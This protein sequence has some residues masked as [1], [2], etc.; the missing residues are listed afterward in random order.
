MSTAELLKPQTEAVASYD[1]L[2]SSEVISRMVESVQP[3]LEKLDMDSYETLNELTRTL[4]ALEGQAGISEFDYYQNTQYRHLDIPSEKVAAFINGKTVLVSGGTGLIGSALL[5]ELSTFSPSRLVSISRGK[6]LPKQVLAGVEYKSVDIRDSLKL[7]EVMQQVQPDIVYHVAADKYN[8]E[9]EGRA[10]HTLST[11]VMGMKNMLNTAEA[12]GVGH[13]IYASTGK[14]SRPY[15]PDIYASSKKAGEML[16]ALKAS[17]GNMLCTAGRFTH[18]VDD[19]SLVKKVTG[20]IDEGEPVCIHNPGT[21]FY[22]QSA[23]ES[24]QLLINAGLEAEPGVLKIQAIRNLGMPVNLAKFG[25]GAIARAGAEVPIYFKGIEQGYEEKAWPGLYHPLTAVD[26]GPLT[27]S[28]EA[29]N[30]HPSPTCPEIDA[31][32][33]ELVDSP[34]L[35]QA[36][37]KL[38]D[39]LLKPVEN[40]NSSLRDA[41]QEL[42][43]AMLD[44]RLDALP[45]ELLNRTN[46]HV[47]SLEAH[48]PQL[49][50]HIDVNRALRSAI[51]RRT[52]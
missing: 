43:W 40:F 51:A 34:S 19:S 18:V 1:Y 33:L 30:A 41:N 25:I 22:V 2:T 27:S 36:Y 24:A 47:T 6:M 44:A 9:A 35:C 42:S 5:R 3:G 23:R 32:P 8:H 21:W 48:E 4:V 13:F 15:S 49:S 50:E 20:W 29:D 45:L 31:F 38:E 12:V 28:L 46:K 10:Y 39:K 16:L 37:T 17:K 14:A 26:V 52:K 7:D 11:N